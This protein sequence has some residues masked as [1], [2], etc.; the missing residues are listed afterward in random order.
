M[1]AFSVST[2]SLKYDEPLSRFAVNVNLR[3]Y[4]LAL[5]KSPG[6]RTDAGPDDRAHWLLMVGGCEG[7]GLILR[8]ISPR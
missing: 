4:S 8:E 5:H 6:L 7:M 3:L 2:I 1:T